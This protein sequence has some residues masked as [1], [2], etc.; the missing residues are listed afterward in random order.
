MRPE[1]THALPYLAV[2]VRIELIR[3]CIALADLAG[4]QALV[5]E[6]DEL[7]GR[8]PGLGTLAVEAGELRARLSAERESI[9]P[10]ESALT[11][12][13]LRL[14]PM[15]ATH[16]SFPQIA[17]EMFLSRHTVKSE[18]LSI[19]RKLGASSRNQAVERARDIGLLGAGHRQTLGCSSPG[20]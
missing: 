10:G 12:A 17:E 5:R 7:L 20:A 19:Y 3:A 18:A 14:L 6:V 11:G 13:E 8:Q 1:L 16:L 2:Q 9:A 15:L 4:A